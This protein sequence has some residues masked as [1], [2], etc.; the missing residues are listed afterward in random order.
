MQ[1]TTRAIK[2]TQETRAVV[3]SHAGAFENSS[4]P[5]QVAYIIAWAIKCCS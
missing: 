4:G 1:A 2:A 5:R 3:E